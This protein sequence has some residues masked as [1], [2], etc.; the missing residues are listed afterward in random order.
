MTT[1]PNIEALTKRLILAVDDDYVVKSLQPEIFRSVQI[2]EK[3]LGRGLTAQE[4]EKV[5]QRL[6]RVITK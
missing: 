2:I 4:T 6:T 3:R 5:L 1:N